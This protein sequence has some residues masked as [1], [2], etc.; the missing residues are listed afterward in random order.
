MQDKKIYIYIKI[1]DHWV[2]KYNFQ[3]IPVFFCCSSQQYRIVFFFLN[4]P[5]KLLYDIFLTKME[6]KVIARSN[7]SFS[8]F[9]HLP[10]SALVPPGDGG[11]SI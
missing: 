2:I 7:Y 5:C 4:Q 6:T 3:T 11:V 9:K 1:T 10:P 8:F